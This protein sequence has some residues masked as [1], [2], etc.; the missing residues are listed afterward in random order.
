M[1]R[2]SA[3][4]LLLLIS[5]AIM[6][7][8]LR[9]RTL[10]PNNG[11]TTPQ[12]QQADFFLENF[13][14]KQFNRQGQLDY[15]LQ[16]LRLEHFEHDDST[17][18]QQPDIALLQARQPHHQPHQP[19]WHITAKQAQASTE[20]LDEFLLTGDVNLQ[21][22]LQNSAKEQALHIQTQQLL[23]KPKAQYAESTSTVT[24][25]HA[26]AIL[27]AKGLQADLKLGKHTFTQVKGR[28]H[29]SP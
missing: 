4:L 13:T 18:I 17:H 25:Q 26:Q 15:R 28:Y 8:W 11:L 20:A 29:V 3:I 16:G 2:N 7:S 14:I 12:T 24:M 5:I 1:S 23:L 6:S 21:Q 27:T 9:Q 10:E 22:Q 19:Q